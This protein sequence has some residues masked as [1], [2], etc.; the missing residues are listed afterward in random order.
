MGR[1]VA[2]AGAGFALAGIGG[3]GLASAVAASPKEPTTPTQR[4]I[5]LVNRAGFLVSHSVRACNLQ[6]SD[7]TPRL[8]LSDGSPDPAMLRL[9]GV[10]RRAPTDEELRLTSDE[11][12]AH[13]GVVRLFT[14]FT[15]IVHAPNGFTTTLMAGV[16]QE[17]VPALDR[18][19]C[20]RRVGVTLT[21]LLRGQPRDVRRIALRFHRNFR[22]GAR[23]RRP[24]PMLTYQS[25]G[26]GTGGAFSPRQ[27]RTHGLFTYGGAINPPPL[28][29]DYNAPG[30]LRTLGH[31]YE[32]AGLVPDGV[33][34]VTVKLARGK[35][36]DDPDRD[37]D[38]IVKRYT[39]TTAVDQNTFG[40][41]VPEDPVGARMSLV[42]RNRAGRV[43]RVVR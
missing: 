3:F 9:L 26:G 42:W 36:G 21:R 5:S 7:P 6:L 11:P 38:P 34:S 19:A 35:R 32:V 23:T 25:E 37:A 8:T 43:I 31:H 22:L 29:F 4:A 28:G 2:V 20:Q 40:F 1:A 12:L 24:V 14:R 18:P 41:R 17:S 13:L 33:A 10:L 27:F 39:A 15:R 30:A 16:V